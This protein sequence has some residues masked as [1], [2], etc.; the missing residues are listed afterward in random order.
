MGVTKKPASK[1]Q[2]GKAFKVTLTIMETIDT[3]RARVKR[4]RL[5][6]ADAKERTQ[7]AQ[8]EENYGLMDLR[9]KG[10]TM[11]DETEDAKDTYRNAVDE[12]W[13]EY[14]P[15]FEAKLLR[16]AD[17]FLDEG[18]TV[19]QIEDF[20]DEEYALTLPLLRDGHH[21]GIRITL[22]ES[23]ATDDSLEGIAFGVDLDADCGHVIGGMTPF[24][25]TSELWIPLNSTH[26]I[27]ERWAYIM[28]SDDYEA[29]HVLAEHFKTCESLSLKGEED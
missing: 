3:I 18:W 13:T 28:H 25:Y 23:L 11:L 22:L 2:Q 12:L 6:F 24:N 1:G 14:E 9:R 29:E 27:A 17:A 26:A 15:K 16:L 5:E 19:G 21:A 8:Q 20:S 10:K 4:L 7:R